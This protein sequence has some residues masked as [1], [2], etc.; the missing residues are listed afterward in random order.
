MP[1]SL[2]T[3]GTE[4]PEASF[5]SAWRSLR[6]ICSGLCLFFIE[7]P[8]PTF[9]RF[10]R[11]DSNSSRISFRGAGQMRSDVVDL[12]PASMVVAD[13]VPDDPGVWFYHCHVNDHIDAG[14]AARYS[15]EE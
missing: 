7:S 8:P 5:S 1:S 3:S 13:M 14:M 9:A 10:G 15:V 11:L 6:T 2:A 4:A 12:L